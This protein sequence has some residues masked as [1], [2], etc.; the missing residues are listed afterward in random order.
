[1]TTTQVVLI[2]SPATQHTRKVIPMFDININITKRTTVNVTT[3]AEAKKK[4]SRLWVTVV[5]WAG[6]IAATIAVL[7]DALEVL[8]RIGL[9]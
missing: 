3:D 1:M 8:E 9:M 7:A 5:T 2:G 4:R 6:A